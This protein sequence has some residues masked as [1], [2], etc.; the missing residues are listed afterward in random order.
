MR[1][2]SVARIGAQ[3]ACAVLGAFFYLTNDAGYTI[4]FM[5]AYSTIQVAKLLGIASGTFHRWIREN[6]VE[7][8]PAQTLGG[9]Q[10]RLWNDADIAKVRKYKAEHYWGKGGRKKRSN[11]AK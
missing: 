4:I 2:S 8:P 7:A 10:V 3:A 1:Y 5:K 9:M 6:R 11:K